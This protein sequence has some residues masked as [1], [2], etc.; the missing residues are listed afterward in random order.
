MIVKLDFSFTLREIQRLEVFGTKVLGKILGLVRE[1]VMEGWI[2]VHLH[3]VFI[4]CAFQLI[5]L[6]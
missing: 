6:G 1:E 5:L 3:W 2:R 4:I